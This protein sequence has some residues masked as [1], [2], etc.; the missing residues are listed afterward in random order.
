VGGLKQVRWLPLALVVAVLLVVALYLGLSAGTAGPGFPIDDAWIHQTYARNLARSGRWEYVPGEV[1]A[2]STAPLWTLLLAAGYW[3][4]LPHLAWAYL[5]GAVVLFGLAWS[6]IVLW[7]TLWPALHDKAWLAGVVLVTT[8]PLVWAAVSGMETLFFITLGMALIAL[9][10]WELDKSKIPNPK[11]QIPK[12][13]ISNLQ[14]LLTHPALL[15]LLAGLLILTRPDGLILLLLVGVGLLTWPGS[16]GVRLG[17]VGLFLAAAALPLLP[18]VVFNYGSSGRFWPNTFY[19]KQ[20]EYAAELGR[21]FLARLANL[22]FFS[23]GGPASGWRGLSSAHLLLLP[24]LLLA[25]GQA[26][27][28]DWRERRLR[29]TLP[30]LWAGGH[31]FLY[32]WRLPVSY[33]HGRYLWAALPIW[34][35]YGLAGW[36]GLLALARARLPE[37][38]ARLL[39]LTAGGTF[40]ALL[41]IF[42]LLGANQYADDVALIEGEMVNVARW[43][44]ENSEPDALIAA[45]DIGAIGY[46]AER[47]LLDL[48]GLISPEVVP[49]LGNEREAALADYVRQSEAVY[50]VTAP[51]W[52]YPELTAD[53]RASLLYSS[54]YALTLEQNVNNMAVYRLVP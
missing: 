38:S 46:F 47:P 49:L 34:I 22:L 19:A 41:L 45:H 51:G 24:G 1:S 40:A 11:S 36:Y 12:S 35:L 28:A 7:R 8:W 9:Y 3:L 39:S 33:H 13:P 27:R 26:V 10:Q 52:P 32:A 31:V 18:Y 29:L 53:G 54:G 15:G 6:G 48:A 44:S 2:G 25:A 30:L 5:L 17:R 42:L 14:S 16:A 50:L 23:L 43:L 37:R 20:A 21:P 4:R